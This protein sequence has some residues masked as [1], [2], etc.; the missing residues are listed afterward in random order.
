[1][2]ILAVILGL[3]MPLLACAQGEKAKPAFE[4]GVHYSVLSGQDKPSAANKI[5]VVEMFWYGCGH[6]YTFEPLVQ[7]W[8]KELKDD[9]NFSRSP[10]MWKQRREPADAM[11]THAK[12]YYTANAMGVLDKLH[13]A[14]FDAMHKKNKALISGDEIAQLVSAHGVDG[15]LFVKT[16]DSFAVNA[17]VQQA[18]K[19][20]RT[21]KV[22]GTPEMVVEGY[23]H[24]S[25]TQAGGQQKMLDVAEFLIEKVRAGDL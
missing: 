4:E 7:S 10:A 15:E 1:M 13:M 14:F 25:A 24:I 20:Q 17:Q 11:W 21:Y 3:A 8:K 5:E 16:M 2:R 18:D 19:R 23:Y 6:C 12:L 9:V 22:T